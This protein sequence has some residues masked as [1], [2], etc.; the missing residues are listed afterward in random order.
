MYMYTS[1]HIY[2]CGVT[3]TAAVPVPLLAGDALA[4][5]LA[6]TGGDV[7]P[8]EL[9]ELACRIISTC[10]MRVRGVTCVLS[11]AVTEGPVALRLTR[12]SVET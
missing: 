4:G 6:H 3:C 8:A 11:S 1:L 10:C 7:A 9:T 5:V 12:P 2:D